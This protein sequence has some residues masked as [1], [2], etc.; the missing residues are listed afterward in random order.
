MTMSPNPSSSPLNVPTE[1]LQRCHAL[2]GPTTWRSLAGQKLFITGGTG[3]VGKWLLATLL[4]A[5]AAFGLGCRITVL[6]RD[7]ASFLNHWPAMN[8]RVDWIVGDVR[9][10]QIG[11]EKYDVIIHA[12]TDV[13]AQASPQDV[14]LTC[15]EGTR[16]VLAFARASG[17]RRL[18]LLSS[19]AVYGPIPAGMTHVP[20]THLGGPDPLLANSAYGEGKRVSEWL[21]AQAAADGLDVH[22]A[23]LFAAVGPHLPLNRHFAVGNFLNAAI[24]GEDILVN[25]DGTPFRSYLYAADMA[26]W[27]WAVLLRGQSGRAYNVGA[28]E[29]LSILALAYRVAEVLQARVDVRVAR[30]VPPDHEQQHYVPLT[31]R[32]ITELGLGMPLSLDEA[33]WRTARWYGHIADS[34][35]AQL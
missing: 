28:E 32:A 2:L 33:L 4:D 3:F 5:N 35:K 30:T 19:G 12:A 29:S 25:G 34:K 7:P 13:V 1:D 21:V 24:K 16:Q 6:S 18:L 27:L 11:T 26:A 31:R 9:D 15:L 17:A 23:R 22:V 14:F 8:G 10:F 20:E